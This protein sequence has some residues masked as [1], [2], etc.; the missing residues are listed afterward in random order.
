MVL[1]HIAKRRLSYALFLT[2]RNLVNF[3]Y[4]QGTQQRWMFIG[5]L[6]PS[7]R[8]IPYYIIRYA[9]RFG[10]ISNVDFYAVFSD[11]KGY[12]RTSSC[13]MGNV[14]SRFFVG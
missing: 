14:G 6:S 10:N 5:V 3:N 4:R 7:L 11:D 2:T 12:T 1:K 8:W 9:L 13:G